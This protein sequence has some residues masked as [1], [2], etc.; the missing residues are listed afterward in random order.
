MFRTRIFLVIIS[1]TDDDF[2]KVSDYG[3]TSEKEVLIVSFLSPSQVPR[4]E[5]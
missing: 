3:F 5:S 4:Q 2:L 1:P